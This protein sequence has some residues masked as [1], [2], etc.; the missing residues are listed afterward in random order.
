MTKKTPVR[1]RGL[2]EDPTPMPKVGDTHP[3]WFS[4]REDG[5][6]TILEVRPYDGIFKQWFTWVIVV[7]APRTKKGSMELSV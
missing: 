3:T 4:D 6:S 2:N 7:T 1:M 5:L